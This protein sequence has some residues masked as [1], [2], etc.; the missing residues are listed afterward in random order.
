MK[1]MEV[2]VLTLR[3]RGSTHTYY[4]TK[5]RVFKCQIQVTPYPANVENMVSS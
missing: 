3:I 1:C 2:S 4:V 5:S